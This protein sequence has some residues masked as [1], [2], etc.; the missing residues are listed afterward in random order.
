[1]AYAAWQTLR[2]DD[3]LWISDELEA[4]PA[5]LEAL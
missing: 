4:T 2:E 1:V 5:K 3:D